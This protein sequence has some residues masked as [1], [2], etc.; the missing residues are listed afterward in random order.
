VAKASWIE[1]NADVNA[2]LT[3]YCCRPILPRDHTAHL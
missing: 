1:L 2:S 3:T